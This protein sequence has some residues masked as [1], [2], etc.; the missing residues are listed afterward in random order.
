MLRERQVGQ[1]L[2]RQQ[3]ALRR[4]RLAGSLNELHEYFALVYRVH[5]LVDLIHNAEGT[6]RH[7][8]HT[9]TQPMLSILK[10]L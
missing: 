10:Q 8:L 4:V 7:V 5:P 9:I 3:E 6:D 2:G 1:Q